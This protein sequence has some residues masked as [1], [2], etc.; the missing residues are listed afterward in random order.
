VTLYFCDQA[1]EN[2]ALSNP[3]RNPAHKNIG[4]YPLVARNQREARPV[5]IIRNIPLHRGQ[6]VDNLY[7]HVDNADTS[8]DNSVDKSLAHNMKSL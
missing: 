7:G 4:D 6:A 5:V 1:R 3:N 2:T 8:V